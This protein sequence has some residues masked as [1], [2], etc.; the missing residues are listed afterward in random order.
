MGDT[1]LTQPP[2]EGYFAE[3]GG[4]VED[5]ADYRNLPTAI[6]FSFRF[7][8]TEMRNNGNIKLLAVDGV[9]PTREN[10]ENETYPIANYF[11]AVTRKETDAENKDDIDKFIGWILSSQGQEL[12]EKTG[13]TAVK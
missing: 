4:I 1:P 5:I 9:E 10:I 6:G 11:Y 2:A 8:T 12:I 13:Y 7:Y 3:M